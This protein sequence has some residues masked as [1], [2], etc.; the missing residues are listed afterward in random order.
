MNKEEPY[1]DQA[2]RLKKR[3]Q[4]INDKV[5]AGDKL[6]P[7]EQVH[8]QKKKKTKWKLKYPVIRLLVLCFILL[9][10]IIFSVISYRDNGKKIN[11]I[12]KTSGS[13]VGYE[14]INLEKPNQ[15]DETV[16]E[17]P[18][19]TVEEN[20]DLKEEEEKS[21]TIQDVAGQSNSSNN[22]NSTVQA[23]SSNEAAANK[24]APE[25]N[26]QQQTVTVKNETNAT[27]TEKTSKVVYHTVKPQ[28][29]L[30]KIAMTYYQSQ[31]GIDIIKKANRLQ[32][33]G[34][35]AGQVLKIPLDN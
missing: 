31:K 4:K 14:T 1:R 25:N 26:S 32:N 29:T 6:P 11:G 18:R 19:E 17:E 34:I 16:V 7:R 28:E 9:P 10:I 24:Q 12:E 8:R 30:F 15:A 23:S 5:E 13:S 21:K 27:S 22:S 20:I 2:E 35:Y 33:E 3:I